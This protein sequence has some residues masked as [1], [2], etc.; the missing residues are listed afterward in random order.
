VCVNC[1]FI[2]ASHYSLPAHIF[3][4]HFPPPNLRLTIFFSSSQQQQKA[5]VEEQPAACTFALNAPVGF[6]MSVGQPPP[7]FMNGTVPQ[8]PSTSASQIK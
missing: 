8:F 7:H 2:R 4:N 6:Q 1:V 5:I 3:F